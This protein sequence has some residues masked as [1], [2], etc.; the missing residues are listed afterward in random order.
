MILVGIPFHDAKRYAIEPLLDWLKSADLPDCEVLIRVHRGVYGEKDAV[1][2]QREFFRQEA[3][4]LGATHLLFIG[5]DTIPP[6]DVLQKFLAWN[7]DVVGGVYY[8][9]NQA[10]NGNPNTAVAWVHRDSNF[11]KKEN[12]SK[13]TGLQAVDG[14][15]MDCVLF[16]RKAYE[17]FSFFDYPTND[18]DYPYYDILK[19]KGFTINLDCNVVCK[20]YSAKETY[21]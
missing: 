13:L 2:K 10:S 8:G 19:E 6:L 9:R 17:S 4:R 1:K 7:V 11:N 20:H 3:I 18:D 21:D 5:V 14:M 15:G 16:S 12:L